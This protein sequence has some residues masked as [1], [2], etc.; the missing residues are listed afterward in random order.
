MDS[1]Y[2]QL[3][4]PLIRYSLQKDVVKRFRNLK[5]LLETKTAV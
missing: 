1:C 2:I 4:T 5:R 3:L